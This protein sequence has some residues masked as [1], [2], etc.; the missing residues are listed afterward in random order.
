MARIDISITKGQRQDTIEVRREGGALARFEFPKKGPIPHDFVHLVV[1]DAFGFERAFWGRVAEGA[2]PGEIQEIAK[3]GGHA[4]A[5]R[6]LTPSPDIIELIQAERLV[7]CFEADLWSAPADIETFRSIA[8]AACGQSLA[9]CPPIADAVILAV[10]QCI[11]DFAA[12]WR[13]APSGARFDFRWAD[14]KVASTGG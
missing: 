11:A 1:E 5:S 6:V 9:P 14:G 4:S 3:R 2:D 7:E 12:E 13:A 10:R 8:E